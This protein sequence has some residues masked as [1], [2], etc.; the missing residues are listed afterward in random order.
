MA[1][2]R[3]LFPIFGA[4]IVQI[5]LHDKIHHFIKF[6]DD[7]IVKTLLSFIDT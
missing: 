1:P 5:D 4:S 6:L 7:I 3:T 2:Q